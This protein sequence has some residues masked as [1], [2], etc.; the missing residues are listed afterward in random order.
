MKIAVSGSRSLGSD[1][2]KEYLYD[3]LDR[4]IEKIDCLI[5]GGCREGAE[6]FALDWTYDNGGV[7][8]I[9]RPRGK[10]G[11]FKKNNVLV[12]RCDILLA[13][14]DNH[15]KGT[16]DA[17]DKA[18]KK[19]KKIILFVVDEVSGEHVETKKLNY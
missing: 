8:I 4:N 11:T 5:S 17:I 13:F 19:N 3:V 9:I 12:E 6:K 10:G 16:K 15:S 18:I 14:Y 2:V 7:H 1:K